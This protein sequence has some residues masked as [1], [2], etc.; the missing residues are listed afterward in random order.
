LAFDRDDSG[1][2]TSQ[3]AR[4]PALQLRAGFGIELPLSSHWDACAPRHGSTEPS[5]GRHACAS[6]STPR[7][8][9]ARRGTSAPAPPRPAQPRLDL[10]GLVFPAAAR[11]ACIHGDRQPRALL[12]PRTARAP[13]RRTLWLHSSST[14]GHATILDLLARAAP[15]R[16]HGRRLHCS[17]APGHARFLELGILVEV[18]V[19]GL[20]APAHAHVATWRFLTLLR[21][22]IIHGLILALVGHHAPPG[23]ALDIVIAVGALPEHAHVAT[24]RFR[25]VLGRHVIDKPVVALVGPDV[26]ISALAR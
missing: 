4:P 25:A 3:P 2:C 13:R 21:D 12:A 15:E 9:C 24:W 17:D 1:N 22:H 16:A 18:L 20:A 11:A 23:R 8:A 5:P 10:L 19:L 26:A 14:P 6:A 7:V